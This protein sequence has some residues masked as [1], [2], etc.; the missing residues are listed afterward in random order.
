MRFSKPA[1]IGA[2]DPETEIIARFWQTK[3]R[4]VSLL[5][6]WIPKASDFGIRAGIQAHLAEERRHLRL[7]GTEITRRDGRRNAAAVGHMLDRPFDIVREQPE[8]CARVYLLHY[9]ITASTVFYGERLQP[10]LDAAMARVIEQITRDEE[11]H[12]RWAEIRLSQ[13]R[14][15]ELTKHLDP[16]RDEIEVAMQALWSR[17]WQRL[18]NARFGLDKA[19]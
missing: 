9:G 7:L 8:D 2:E 14:A 11:R 15:R 18:S 1:R 17:P 19:G 5:E 6:D 3:L 13:E 16:V 10:L 4:S 12:I